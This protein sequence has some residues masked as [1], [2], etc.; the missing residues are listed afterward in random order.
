MNDRRGGSVQKKW[1]VKHD[2]RDLSTDEI[3]ETILE[4]R[5]VADIHALLYPSD[6]C[7]IPFDEMK[8]IDKAAKIIADTLDS[9]GSFFVHFDTDTDGVSA[10]SIAVRWLKQHTDRVYYGINQGKEHGIANINLSLLNGIDVLWIVDSIETRMFP[11]EKVLE[12]GVKQIIITDHHLVSKSMQKQMER[13]G[14]ITLV[15]SAV[16]YPNPALSGSATTWKLCAYMDWLELDDYSDDLVDLASTGMI[17]DMVNVGVDS[18]ENRYICFK[19]FNNQVNPALKKIN[20][21]YEFNSQAVSFGIAPLVNASN[22]MNENEKAVELFLSED[23]KE[24][25]RLVNDL[26]SC[27]EYQNMEIAD[28]MPILEEQAEPQIDNKVMF[29]FVETNAEIKG[30]IGN[31]L[32]EKYQ[33]PVIVLSNRVD[34]D[35]NTGE[36]IKHEYF[37]SARAVGVKNFKEYVDN[38]GLVGTG[39]HENAHGLWFDAEVLEDFQNALEYAL[40]DV[41]F[42]QEATVDIQI[43]QEQITD[44]LIKKIKMLNKI[45]GQ[46][47]PSVSVMVSGITDYE[48]GNMSGGK[49]LKLI[50]DDGKLLFIKW[51]FTGDWGQFDGSVSAIGSLDSGFFGRTYYRQL[52][53][54]DWVVDAYE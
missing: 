18:P 37:G 39:G 36:I 50:A 17:A 6:E 20:G 11:Y 45:S 42:V 2:C 12:A 27:K 26:K 49:H 19:G 9:D 3:I 10:G 23:S 46:G 16:D 33:R 48:V 13:T 30:L 24:I 1:T 44:D 8:N 31:K 41:E 28:I 5:G 32:L 34:V 7:L 51:N 14:A 22:R 43:N 4:D 21:S 25:T 38:T 35:E 53:M 15:S 52:I 54:N 29:F 40:K 47:W